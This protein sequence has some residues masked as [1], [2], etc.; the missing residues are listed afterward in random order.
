MT[1]LRECGAASYVPLPTHPLPQPAHGLL[2]VAEIAVVICFPTCFPL[3]S[4]ERINI[5][6]ETN[7]AVLAIFGGIIVF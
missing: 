5:M 1:M 6:A 2:C 7:A 4:R 3:R